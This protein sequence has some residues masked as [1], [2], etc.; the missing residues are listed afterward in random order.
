MNSDTS[1][2]YT[3]EQYSFQYP[4]GKVPALKGVSMRI[5]SGEFV[6]LCGPSGCGKTTFLRQLKSAIAPHGR[7]KGT[8]WFHENMLHDMDLRTQT[9]AIGF[10]SQQPEDQVVTDKVW[11]ELAFGLESLGMDTPAIRR[12]VAEMSH[13]FGIQ[14]WFHKD[15]AELSGGQKQLLNL[16]AVMVMQPEI[17]LLDEPT[18]QLDPIAATDFL[19]MLHRIHQELGTTIVITEHRLEEV[20]PYASRLVYMEKGQIRYEGN[21][22]SVMEWMRHN[23]SPFVEAL[24]APVRI[25]N[26]VPSPFACPITVQEGREWLSECIRCKAIVP[27]EQSIQEQQDKHPA[28]T[29]R[30]KDGHTLELKSLWFRY[31]GDE[32]DVL[33]NMSLKAY[34]GEM[35]AILGGNGSGKSTMLS[36]IY[37]GNK[38]QR[39][40]VIFPDASRRRVISLPQNPELLFVRDTVRE[41]LEDMRDVY[42][43]ESLYDIQVEDMIELC[44]LQAVLD[45]HPYDLSGGEKQRLGLAKVLLAGPDILLLDEPT[46]GMDIEYKEVF[47]QILTTLKEQ[48]ITILM[49][50]HDIEFCA[51]YADRCALVFD[52][53]IAAEGD[54]NTFFVENHFYTTQAHRMARHIFPSAV[55]VSDV[56]RGC[57][58]KSDT[59]KKG[60]MDEIQSEKNRNGSSHGNTSDEPVDICINDC[61][62]DGSDLRSCV[63]V[64]KKINYSNLILFLLVPFTIYAGIRF[65]GDEKYLFVSLLILFETLIPFI[66]SFE[67]RK[68]PARDVVILA[69]M[70]AVGVAGRIAFAAIPQFQP[71]TAI[72]ILA[73][74]AF[75]GETGFLTGAISML[76]SN[77]MFGQGAWTP[78]QMFAMGLVG[79]FAGALFHAWTER[80]MWEQKGRRSKVLL[81]MLCIYG[82]VAVL[83]LYGGIMNPAAA[84]MSGLILTKQT[85]LAYYISGIPFDLLH[86]ASTVLFLILGAR[87]ILKKLERVKLKFGT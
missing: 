53:Q 35:L 63:S 77:M 54:S 39:G 20:L 81:G 7:S 31:P 44:R 82:F 8:I 4:T 32:K 79:F 50:S 25:W 41:E 61:E 10:V 34:P 75:G 60:K 55:T 59:E 11:H 76:V 74:V 12:K 28:K 13:F 15:V 64:H 80:G 42:Q 9:S 48:G 22:E 24:P 38:P 66:L 21:P 33:R 17:L 18:S 51:E 87:P 23:S 40:K 78:W 47:A 84:L 52:G 2:I 85:L 70:C 14:D 72:A 69:V 19:M 67:R 30:D 3:I 37:A 86:A 5:A 36:M 68:P 73:G 45:R 27:C 26:H 49:V 6:V 71:V 29:C 16:A 62:A 46:K 1:V 65:F 57:G 83:I 56:I 58:G 43:G